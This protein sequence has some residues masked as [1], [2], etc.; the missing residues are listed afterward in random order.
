MQQRIPDVSRSVPRRA[1]VEWREADG[2]VTV[3][4]V[5]YGPVRRRV[6]RVFGLPPTLTVHLDPLG[7]EAWRLIDGQR[8]AAAIKAELQVK[9]PG[10]ADL[11]QRLGKFLG[12]MVSRGFVHLG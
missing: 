9:F 7:S 1:D 11:A 10:E 12:A 3:V 8:T 6:L 5:R 2:R 4:R